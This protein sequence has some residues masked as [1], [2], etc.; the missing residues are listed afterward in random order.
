MKWEIKKES[1]YDFILTNNVIGFYKQPVKLKSGR[2]SPYYV[3]WRIISEDVYLLDQLTDFLLLYVE[4]L[5]I[6]PNSFYGVPEGATKLGIIMQ[7]KW[8]KKSQNYRSGSFTLS[9][10][11]GKQKNHGE[12]KDRWYLGVPKGDVV[13]LED[14]TTTGGSLIQT[15]EQL[16]LMNI[17]V[18]GCIAL[19]NRNEIREDGKSVDQVISEKGVRYYAMSSIIDLLPRLNP[20][21]EIVSL[22]EKY[23]AKYGTRSIQ[24]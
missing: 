9:M 3:N 4:Y 1:F 20:S 7:Y 21:K 5:K 2:M 15:I 12:L 14:V 24:F 22:I 11:R 19:T 13:I 18:I 6:S 16:Q 10:G 23:Y 17:N 8:A